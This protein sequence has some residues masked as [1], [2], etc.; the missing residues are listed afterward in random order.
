MIQPISNL[1]LSS[2]LVVRCPNKPSFTQEFPL[3]NIFLETFFNSNRHNTSLMCV[4]DTVLC[5]QY[6]SV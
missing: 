6:I 5:T 2:I 3:F 4:P 1:F